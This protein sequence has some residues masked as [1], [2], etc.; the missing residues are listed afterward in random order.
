MQTSLTDIPQPIW[1]QNLPPDSHVLVAEAWDAT[2]H[3]ETG[4]EIALRLSAY[5]SKVSYCHY[6]SLLQICEYSR[7][8]ALTAVRRMIGY[9]Y[10]PAAAGIKIAL[11]YAYLH[12]LNFESISPPGDLANINYTFNHSDLESIFSLQRASFEGST[13]IGVAVASSLVTILRNSQ[14]RPVEHL[15][16]VN[17]L[18]NSFLRS[19]YIAKYLL[20][21]SKYDAIVLF[22][23]R[24]AA[25][26]GAAIA[27]QR[28]DIPIFYHERGSSKDL[29]SLRPYQPHNRVQV[30]RDIC[31]TWKCVDRNSGRKIAE[32]FFYDKKAGR[33]KGWTTFKQNMV[34]G[35]STSWLSVAKN[36]SR[37]GKI[38]TF[39]SSSEDELLSVSDAFERSP[40]EWNGQDEAFIEIAKSAKKF[41]HALIL[42]NHP[43]LQKKSDD[44][45]AKWDNLSFM[46]D[47]RDIVIVESGSPVDTYELISSSDL[48]IVHGSTVGIEAVYWGKPVITVSD[49]FY[50]LIGASIYKP[51]AVADLDDLIGRIQD[52]SVRPDSALPYGYYM[53][54]FGIEYQL[55]KPDTLFRGKIL[56]RDLGAKSRRLKAISAI[57]RMIL[58]GKQF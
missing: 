52:L 58:R 24:F 20:D 55:Y 42:R 3:L 43:H 1:L 57:K 38:I 46:D 41:G 2:P 51:Q 27:A 44:D 8:F 18:A 54:T 48:I 29:F 26:K 11:D 53:S 33:D 28:L 34:P 7:R 25:V 19:Y 14:V 31:N 22:N 47:K 6:G 50:D 16:L 5:Y 23:G 15:S 32:T 13:S 39:F 37:T 12:G 21:E 4:L 9:N 49:S 10:T 56:G 17:K 30:Q 35:Q 45:R 36:I 40:F